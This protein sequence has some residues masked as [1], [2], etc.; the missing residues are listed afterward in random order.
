MQ[1]VKYTISPWSVVLVKIL[2]AGKKE[3]I[4]RIRISSR[5]VSGFPLK[6]GVDPGQSLCYQTS[7]WSFQEMDPYW[8][9]GFVTDYTKAFVWITT[10]CGKF[11]K[12]WEYQTTLPAS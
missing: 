1:W 7:V 9:L 10:N 12:K 11:F 6:D 4:L 3:H 5:K 2:Q 8:G